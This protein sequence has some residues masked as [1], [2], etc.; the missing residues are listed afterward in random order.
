MSNFLN[1]CIPLEALTPVGNEQTMLPE[2]AAAL[3][4]MLDA[5]VTATGNDCPVVTSGYR[6]RADQQWQLDHPQGQLIAAVG[7]STHGLGCTADLSD[8][9]RTPLTTFSA[10]LD[11]NAGHYGARRA[12]PSESWHYQFGFAHPALATTHRTEIPAAPPI[13]LDDEMIRIQST[14]RGIAIIGAGYFRQLANDEEVAASSDIITKTL[15]GNDRQFDLWRSL[16]TGGT[17]APLAS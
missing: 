13:E 12:V 17:S 8:T 7:Q 1:G 10:W 5:Y 14:A 9:G 15:V 3:T 11:A 6:S 2:Y 16:A 4:A